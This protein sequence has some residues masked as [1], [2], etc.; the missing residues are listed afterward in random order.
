MAFSYAVV[1]FTNDD[2]PS[3][4]IVHQGWLDSKP[5]GMFCY[6]PRTN[7]SLKAR[8][9]EIADKEKWV[10]YSIRILHY[11]D[12]YESA[13]Q[14]CRDAQYTSNLSSDDNEEMGRGQRTKQ[15]N[16]EKQDSKSDADDEEEMNVSK[17]KKLKKASTPNASVLNHQQDSQSTPIMPLG[18]SE[19]RK[20]RRREIRILPD[21]P[22]E[23]RLN[24]PENTSS[25]ERIVLSTLKHVVK[26]QENIQAE[27]ALI[28]GAAVDDEIEDL[29]P[30]PVN[31]LEDFIQ[32]GIKLEEKQSRKKLAS[33]LIAFGGATCLET[34]RNILKKTVTNNILSLYSLRGK[35]GKKV[36]QDHNLYRVLIRACFKLHKCKRQ[37]IE[38]C[39]IEVLKHAPHMPGGP[40]YKKPASRR[41]EDISDSE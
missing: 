27:L 18:N 31:S 3:V 34:V 16:F 2:P 38:D 4:A 19:R 5:D 33:F 32:W 22:E 39:M 7:V 21:L 9:A 24:L 40:K 1:E 10:K 12:T 8:K 17:R 11:T 36:F 23:G 6:W 37:E 30:S 25:F 13:I 15:Q 20:E 28:S 41:R 26:N 35:K 29:L 14:M